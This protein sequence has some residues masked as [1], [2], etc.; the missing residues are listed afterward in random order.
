[1]LI[2]AES[3][4]G[5]RSDKVHE[6]HGVLVDALAAL[7]RLPGDDRVFPWDRSN[8]LIYTHLKAIH[9]LAGL[10]TDRRS[11]FHRMR[12]TAASWFKFKGGDP[13]Q[14]LDHCDPKT[15]KKYLDLRICGTQSAAALL[16]DPTKGGAR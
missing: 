15:T 14:L 11:M 9:Q 5:R 1:M 3:R 2:P 12:R 7:K 13:T 8:N 4:K 10:P 6:L 16:D